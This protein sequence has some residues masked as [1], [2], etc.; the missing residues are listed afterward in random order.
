[1]QRCPANANAPCA[2]SAAARARSA[3]SQTMA[4]LLPPS[5]A[6]SG[7]RRRAQISCAVQPAS[8]EP[9]SD[10]ASTPGSLM[11]AAAARWSPVTIPSRPSG[12]PASRASASVNSASRVAGGAG[13][14][15]T[16]LPR[17]RAGAIFPHGI[18]TGLFQGVTT[19]TT[20]TGTRRNAESGPHGWIPP[21]GVDAALRR[22]VA[23]RRV[24]A[25]PCVTGFPIPVASSRAIPSVAAP[26]RSARRHSGRWR[27]S[28]G[29]S[30]QRLP[31]SRA[32]ATAT[33]I[34]GSGLNSSEFGS[35]K[36]EEFR[37][38]PAPKAASTSSTGANR[39][40]RPSRYR[41]VT[42]A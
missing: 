5:S 35:R 27:D 20:P 9:E 11:S 34:V 26:S 29:S 8:E 28:T 23:A 10:T 18:A 24:S 2:T 25:S 36:A 16:A 38:D 15:T 40:A 19:A 21:A 7:M 6:W 39:A 3:P 22:S 1:M 12:S 13:F 32:A 31:A 30:R 33:P 17:A 4:A 14:H 41:R 42:A 37:P